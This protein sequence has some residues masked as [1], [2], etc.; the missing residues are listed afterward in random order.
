MAGGL[1]HPNCKDGHTTYFPGISDK[2]EKVTKK[3]MKAGSNCRKTGK[4]GKFNTEKHR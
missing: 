4:Q 1:Y 3:E 2:P